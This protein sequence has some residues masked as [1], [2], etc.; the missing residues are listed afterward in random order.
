MKPKNV[1]AILGSPHSIREAEKAG[2]SITKINLLE[3]FWK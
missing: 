3:R 2:Y 1:L